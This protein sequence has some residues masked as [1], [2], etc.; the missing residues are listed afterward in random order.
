VAIFLFF[1]FVAL[2]ICGSA[3]AGYV[4]AI[5]AFRPQHLSD[6]FVLI[7]GSSYEKKLPNSAAVGLALA[8]AIPSIGGLSYAVSGTSWLVTFFGLAGTYFWAWAAAAFFVGF[9]LAVMLRSE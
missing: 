9:A 1:G 7:K 5:Y 6:L 8:M 2:L 4:L 3:A